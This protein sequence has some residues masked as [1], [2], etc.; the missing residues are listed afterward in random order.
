MFPS[1]KNNKWHD[2]V[3]SLLLSCLLCFVVFP[4]NAQN[5]VPNPSYE[6]ADT[7]QLGLGFRFPEQ[8]P[9]NWFSSNGTPDHLQSCLP[10][11]SA[12]G[13]PVNGFTFQQPFEG[14]SCIGMFSFY[15][16]GIEEQREWVMVELLEPLVP[17]RTYYGSFHANAGFGGATQFPQIWLA[18][19]HIGMLFTMEAR[20]WDFA[21]PNPAYPNHAHIVRPEILADTVAWSLVSGSFV[22]DSAYRYLM[23]GN[24]FNNAMTDTLHFADPNSVFPWYPRGYTLIDRVC[25][26]EAPDG[27]E[28][29]HAIVEEVVELP[30]VYP[31]PATGMLMID[32]AEGQTV[33]IFDAL[34]KVVWSGRVYSERQALGVENW[35][36]GI[37]V[38][39]LEGNGVM[40]KVKFVLKE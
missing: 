26:S 11:G 17:G 19:S 32:H 37:Y 4:C 38:L 3:A 30:N 35:A 34:G 27:C 22:A 6:E 9:L 5:R 13:L 33:K 20:Q 7:C 8:G 24:F 2:R 12:N 25:V 23:I 31:N 16:N 21:S 36:R 10:Y 14:S 28:V 1:L 15:Q 29:A 39:Q 40:K 18:S